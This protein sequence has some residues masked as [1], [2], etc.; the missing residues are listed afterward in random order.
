MNI[1]Q[2]WNLVGAS[3]R[4]FRSDH[5]DGNM[6]RQVEALREL[7][8]KIPPNEVREF[9]DQMHSLLIEAYTWDLWGAAELLAR[10]HCSDDFFTDFR[11]WLIS[12]GRSR[13]EEALVD[14]DSLAGAAFLPG[15]EG[16]FFE[17]FQHVAADVFEEMTG[18]EIEA[19][20]E[21][22]P[23]HPRG[24]MWWRTVDDL[25][26]RYPRIWDRLKKERTD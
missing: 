25:R 7:L 9:D 15:V 20:T 12:M 5:A 16:V 1:D 8:S 21:S 23:D 11:S 17:E 10:G 13:F 24:S 18:Q 22:Y 19:Y 14:P 26:E 6:E 3:R 2:F 4:G